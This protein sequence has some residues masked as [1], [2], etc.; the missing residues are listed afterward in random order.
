MLTLALALAAPQAV[1]TVWRAPLEPL[2]GTTSPLFVTEAVLREDG[3]SWLFSADASNTTTPRLQVDATGAQVAQDSAPGPTYANLHFAPDGDDG[4]FHAG[5]SFTGFAVGHV[6]AGGTQIAL[7]TEQVLQVRIEEIRRDP[8][9]GVHVF[10]LLPP[11]ST[12]GGMPTSSVPALFVASYD[13]ALNLEWATRIDTP[14][15]GVSISAR[16]LSVSATGRSFF[17]GLVTDQWSWTSSLYAS[18]DPSGSL[19]WTRESPLSSS[20]ADIQCVLALED[21][22]S[23]TYRHDI[24]SGGGVVAERIE[25]HRSDGSLERV[26]TLDVG[27]SDFTPD[28]GGML[29]RLGAGTFGV[30]GSQSLPD[31]AMPGQNSR[32]P[33]LFEAVGTFQ[34]NAWALV[35]VTTPDQRVSVFG[36]GSRSDE[37]VLSAWSTGPPTP[38]RWIARFDVVPLGTVTACTAQSNS[39]G[40]AARLDAVGSSRVAE[41]DLELV[42]SSLPLHQSTLFIA[43]RD[44]GV[45]AI[46]G[47]DGTLCL[48]GSI[49]RFVGPGQIRSSGPFGLSNLSV[50]LGAIPLG[51]S[52]AA[53]SVGETFYFQAW[54]RDLNPTLTSNLTNAI[55]VTL[56]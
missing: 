27:L 32:V 12:F 35:P 38:T 46:P 4:Y 36:L 53:A 21:G 22:R 54:Y 3:G 10:G 49:G 19:L 31:P 41:G 18:I 48:G 50:D 1:T 11:S 26:T 9:G 33:T 51:A 30:L 55:G 2:P 52:T 16:D 14:A 34:T 15:T 23:A 8:T 43:S 6:D 45:Q 24:L 44:T 17:S 5:Q 39:T 29:F 25:E 40:T 37:F 42:A 56:L 28:D 13:D 7:A 47:S 20:Q